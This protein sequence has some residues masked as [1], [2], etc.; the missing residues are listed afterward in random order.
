MSSVG[1]SA[2]NNPMPSSMPPSSAASPPSTPPTSI[3]TGRRATR[4]V[5][6]ETIIGNW[7]KE[8]G[9]RARIQIHTKGGAPRRTGRPRQRQ[10]HCGLSNQSRGGFAAPP[11]HRLHRPRR[12]VHYDDKVTPPAE[13]LGALQRLIEQGKIRAIGASNYSPERLTLAM[14]ASAETRPAALLVLANAVQPRRPCCL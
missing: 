6:R 14:E 5:S 3:R 11:R 12:D 13:T 4:V 9:N 1:A 8:R 10:C 7:M 2:R